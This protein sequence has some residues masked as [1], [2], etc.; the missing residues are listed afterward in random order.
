MQLAIFEVVNDTII[1]Y[2]TYIFQVYSAIVHL[3]CVI[4]PLTKIF[5]SKFRKNKKKV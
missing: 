5:V 1:K 4:E 3:I 2:R